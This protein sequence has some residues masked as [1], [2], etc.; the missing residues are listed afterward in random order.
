MIIGIIGIILLYFILDFEKTKLEDEIKKYERIPEFR[1][2]IEMKWG[3]HIPSL[4]KEIRDRKIK[5][6]LN[7]Q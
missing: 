3:N 1:N 5:S 6:I 4:K 7:D 2:H